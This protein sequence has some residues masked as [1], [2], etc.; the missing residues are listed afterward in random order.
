[1]SPALGSGQNGRCPDCGQF[2][3]IEGYCQ[4]LDPRN[5]WHRDE[6]MQSLARRHGARG[7]ALEDETPVEPET[8]DETITETLS[9]D[10]TLNECDVCGVSFQPKRASARYCSSACRLKAHRRKG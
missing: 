8:P 3:L 2:H 7:S 6:A 4:A 5:A 1:M 9:D 10:E